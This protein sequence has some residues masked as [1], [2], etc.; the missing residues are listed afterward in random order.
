MSPCESH[1]S[2][3]DWVQVCLA[4]ALIPGSSFTGIMGKVRKLFQEREKM[5]RTGR[6]VSSSSL[7]HPRR[8]TSYPALQGLW[9]SGPALLL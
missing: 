7:S 2:R 4:L 5:E 8:R 6:L 1:P 3:G 9:A